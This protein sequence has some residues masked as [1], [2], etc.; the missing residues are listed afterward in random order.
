MSN[1]MLI[2]IQ[3]NIEEATKKLE[4]RESNLKIATYTL[5]SGLGVAVG[6]ATGTLVSAAVGGVVGAGIAKVAR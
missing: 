4:A 5:L 2:G 6:L 1:E 3:S